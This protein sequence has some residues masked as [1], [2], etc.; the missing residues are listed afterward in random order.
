[1]NRTKFKP[2]HH[3]SEDFDRYKREL[4]SISMISALEQSIHFNE[5]DT[6]G[7]I[8]EMSIND[9]TQQVWISDINKWCVSWFFVFIKLILTV[10]V[11]Y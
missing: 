3:L 2:T 9:F 4:V 7:I 5:F 1:M 8:I 10:L 11:Y 6:V